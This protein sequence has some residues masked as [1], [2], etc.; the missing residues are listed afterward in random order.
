MAQILPV[1]DALHFVIV[2]FE[3][4]SS[5]AWANEDWQMQ[6]AIEAFGKLD[7]HLD[8]YVATPPIYFDVEKVIEAENPNKPI[9]AGRNAQAFMALRLMLPALR[10][11]K[12]QLSVLEQN[13]QTLRQNAHQ[14]R[15]TLNQLAQGQEALRSEVTRVHGD[16]QQQITQLQATVSRQLE[17]E[18]TQAVR[19]AAETGRQDL[20][21]LIGGAPT[22]QDARAAVSALEAVRFEDWEPM[23]FAVKPGTSIED[24]NTP[25]Y[26]GPCWGPEFADI[27]PASQGL[28]ILDGNRKKA[29]AMLG[30]W[31]GHQ[32]PSRHNHLPRHW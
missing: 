5:K 20:L 4:I 16:L 12:V 1:V 22:L 23:L 29:E 24:R 17:A 8:V 25:A 13:Q 18:V 14:T 7:E 15:E 26:I 19:L 11:M 10:G 6:A 9:H 3:Y 21:S 32:R 28:E 2:P 27:I 31:G 30:A